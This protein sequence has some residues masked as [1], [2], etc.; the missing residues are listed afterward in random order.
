MDSD[1]KIISV[2]VVGGGITFEGKEIKWCDWMDFMR[3]E[4]IFAIQFIVSFKWIIKNEFVITFLRWRV[5]RHK[6]SS[7]SLWNRLNKGQ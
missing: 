5:H 3:F 7:Q 1:G 4:I 2:E 6:V